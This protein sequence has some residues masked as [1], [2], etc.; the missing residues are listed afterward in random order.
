MLWSNSSEKRQKQY[1]YN[2]KNLK[3]KKKKMKKEEIGVD[4]ARI[5]K[6]KYNLKY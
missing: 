6:P 5:V 1:R 2:L 4:A 3:G